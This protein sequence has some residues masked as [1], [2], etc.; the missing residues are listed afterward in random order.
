MDKDNQYDSRVAVLS[1]LTLEQK[2]KIP[3]DA[4]V[5]KDTMEHD[6]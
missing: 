4:T 5:K 6:L 2:S 3:N 1:K